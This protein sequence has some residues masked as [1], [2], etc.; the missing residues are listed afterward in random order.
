MLLLSTWTFGSSKAKVLLFF[1]A[2]V[3]IVYPNLEGMGSRQSG[4]RYVM[5]RVNE[6]SLCSQMS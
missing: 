4:Q 2:L 5:H 3:D 1:V 6:I